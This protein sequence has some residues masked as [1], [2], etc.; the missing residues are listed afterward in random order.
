[1]CV[2]FID[3]NKACPKNSYPLP[4]IDRLMDVTSRY[5][6]L[7]FMD[8]YFGYN[9]IQMHPEDE[10]KTTFITENAKLLLSSHAIRAKNACA[11]YKL[12]M[13][14]VFAK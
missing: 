7:I 8:A 14:K 1:M 3:L 10:E 12:L 13:N 4:N 2:D 6:Y 11:T 5:R 9:Q